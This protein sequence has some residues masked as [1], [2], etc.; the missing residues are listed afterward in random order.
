MVRSLRYLAWTLVRASA[1]VCLVV[2]TPALGESQAA[3]GSETLSL[4]TSFNHY[5]R[6][7]LQ[8]AGAGDSDTAE[9]MLEEIKRLRVERNAFALH[10]VGMC[11]FIKDSR[12]SKMETSRAHAATSRSRE[13]SA[14][15]YPPLAGA[16]RELTSA[17]ARSVTPPQSFTA[18]RRS[19]PRFDRSVTGR[20]RRG[21]FCSSSL[22][23]SCSSS[24]YSPWPC[25]IAMAFS[26]S[27]ISK[28]GSAIGS[29]AKGLWRRRS[30]RCSCR[31]S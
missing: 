19:S 24:P 22:R 3:D 4:H 13:I 26:S 17:R 6:R 12:F 1:V 29:G 25:C 5:W 15:I 14:R 8:A 16:W 18:C 28:S 11:S 27:T 31:S 7:Y 10:D 2:T 23:A 9:R 20:T 21:T 30:E